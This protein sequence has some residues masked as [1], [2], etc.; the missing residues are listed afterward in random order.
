MESISALTS[1]CLVFKSGQLL[2][3]A[4]TDKAVRSYIELALAGTDQGQA[5]KAT[6]SDPDD[7]Y[8]AEALVITSESHGQHVWGEPLAV[9]FVLH[10]GRP[11]SKLCFYFWVY[12]SRGVAVSQFWNFNDD[13]PFRKKPGDYRMRC[14]IPK[15]RLYKGRYTIKA[16][17]AD[18]RGIVNMETISEICPF[19]IIMGSYVRNAYEWWEDMAKYLE[20]FT[21]EPVTQA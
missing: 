7:N 10:I 16:C 17:L 3:D 5:Y 8:I 18:S 9:E 20:E 2:I 4:P 13:L 19:E 11:M 1:R 15:C 6:K 14:E 21:W 12:D